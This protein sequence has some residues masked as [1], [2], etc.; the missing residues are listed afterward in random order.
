M[1][2]PLVVLI[3]FVVLLALVIGL[4]LWRDRRSRSVPGETDVDEFDGRRDAARAFQENE[5]LRSQ[6]RGLGH[7]PIGGGGNFIP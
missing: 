1:L 2:T 3:G 4:I 7:N 6:A 5:T